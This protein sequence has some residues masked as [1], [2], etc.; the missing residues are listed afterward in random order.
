MSISI[1]NV[2]VIDNAESQVATSNVTIEDK[3][4]VFKLKYVRADTISEIPHIK[5]I[6]KITV[7]GKEVKVI[8]ITEGK[9]IGREITEY[10]E[11]FSERKKFAYIKKHK[12]ASG[13]L[14]FCVRK[15]SEKEEEDVHMTVARIFLSNENNYEFV[16]HLDGNR[17]N[18]HFTNLIWSQFP[19]LNPE[20]FQQIPEFSNYKIARDSTIQSYFNSVP[21]PIKSLRNEKGYMNTK[22]TSDKG[23]P[24][25]MYVHRLVAL[26]Y[27][28]NPDNLPEVHHIDGNTEHNHV[29][30]LK[31]V[32]K[33]ENCRERRRRKSLDQCDLNGN[34]I[35][36][37]KSAA[38][39]IS[40]LN[41]QITEE[42][43]LEC[44]ERNKL[45][46]QNLSS[47]LDIVWKFKSKKIFVFQE[48]E[49]AVKLVGKFRDYSFNYPHYSITNYG[50]IFNSEGYKKCV[51]FEDICPT[52][53][54]SKDG[55]KEVYEVHIL[56]A[57]FF[58]DANP[59]EG[60]IVDHL[61]EDRSNPR[62]DNL[63]WVTYSENAKRAA[64]KKHKAVNKIDPKTGQVLKSYKSIISAAKDIDPDNAEN[65]STSISKCC[66]NFQD[67]AWKFKWEF[68]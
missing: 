61:D 3:P 65:I 63:E 4:R 40:V 17:S 54:L 38:E 14:Y 45:D 30:N 10:G 64:H 12:K 44:A 59:P 53:T 57:L 2:K 6:R 62:F 11:I 56:V 49:I 33:E 50:N 46:S 34:F 26:T 21:V 68:V 37:F 42:K 20:K 48:G 25:N 58:V 13:L 18:N 31:W 41:L 35:R 47:A 51:N 19:E 36:E 66:N 29:E 7:D 9:F 32:T 22:I 28:P 1:E 24:T 60:Y 5:E 8:K 67:T 23:I 55:Y 16:L 52:Y 27:I 43:I 15:A 39:A